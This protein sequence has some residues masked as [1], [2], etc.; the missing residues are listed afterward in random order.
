MKQIRAKFEKSDIA[1]LPKVL[2]EGRIIVILSEREADRAVDYLLRQPI[3]GFDTET[4]PSFRRGQMHKVAL[5]QVS[6]RD[7]AFLFR[8]NRIGLTDSIVRLLE[9]K[10]VLKVGLSL[11]DDMHNLRLRRD[12]QPGTYVELQQEVQRLGVEDMSLQKLYANLLGGR[13]S[14]TQQLT[15]WEADVLTEAQQRY[16]ATDA[17]A[18]I[19]IHREIERLLQTGDY[20][21]IE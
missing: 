9:D 12:F 7:T 15:N 3:L 6:T 14:K 13:I 2:F 20:Q 10:R 11:K 18:C 5:L 17:W 19:Q 8:L 4:R 16:A 1:A 21:L